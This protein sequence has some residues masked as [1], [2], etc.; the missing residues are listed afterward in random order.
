M[1]VLCTSYLDIKFSCILVD[2]YLRKTSSSWPLTASILS[3]AVI[4]S[5]AALR[6]ARRGSCENAKGLGSIFVVP[7]AAEL[8][9]LPQSIVGPCKQS[10]W[11]FFAQP[12][13]LPSRVPPAPSHPALSRLSRRENSCPTRCLAAG[14]VRTCCAP[15]SPLSW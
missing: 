3:I 2:S 6:C 5:T 9:D 14:P 15:G 13:S 4:S 10:S 12:G 7:A 11:F 8:T 1:F